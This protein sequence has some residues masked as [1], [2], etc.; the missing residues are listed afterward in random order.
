MH[1]PISNFINLKEE[2]KNDHPILDNMNVHFFGFGHVN[3]AIFEKMSASYQLFGDNDYKITYFLNAKNAK[4]EGER[5]KNAYSDLDL[6][7]E[8]DNQEEYFP[9]PHLYDLKV[10]MANQDI[11]NQKIIDEYIKNLSPDNHF[12][13]NGFEMFIVSCG[14]SNINGR[15]AYFIRN[16]ILSKADNTVDL[17]KTVIFV[18]MSKED[19]INVFIK[20]GYVLRQNQF[21]K[22]FNSKKLPK[23]PI[24]IIGEDAFISNY[25]HNHYHK[26]LSLSLRC[27][28]IYENKDGNTIDYLR[29]IKQRIK[30]T[31]SKKLQVLS[32]IAPLWQIKSKLSVLGYD[33]D[34]D[35][36]LT[37]EQGEMVINNDLNQKFMSLFPKEENELSIIGKR[38]LEMEHNRW[39]AQSYILFGYR[40]LKKSLFLNNKP[41]NTK[42]RFLA[43]HICMTTNE[44]L[45]QLRDFVLDDKNEFDRFDKEE[46]KRVVYDYDF[47][48]LKNITF[49]FDYDAVERKKNK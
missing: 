9:L 14:G 31:S 20:N 42:G 10:G 7:K 41:M 16:A 35:Y 21:L 2:I 37:N 28:S 12:K 17:R 45:K 27:N 5:L 34:E 47:G 48:Y 33:I 23:V 24:V 1:N 30:W 18:R 15:I 46:I 4:E 32:N 44:G 25:V 26:T 13:E 36:R 49:I 43:A 11:N 22:G 39:M 6:A 40:P 3:Q 8:Y 19:T 38:L 29:L